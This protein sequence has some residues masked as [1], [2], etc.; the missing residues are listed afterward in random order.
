MEQW[1]DSAYGATIK[2]TITIRDLDEG[3]KTRL[4]I[5]AA[6]NG[7]SIE[8][9]A[10][11]ILLAALDVETAP[12][13]DLATLIR[14][15]FKPL[16]GAE[17][18]IPP[19]DAMRQPP[20][21]GGAINDGP[22]QNSPVGGKCPSKIT[23]DRFAA[24]VPGWYTEYMDSKYYQGYLKLLEDLPK[25]VESLG[26]LEIEDLCRIAD[27]GGNQH[28]V[29][30]NL[31]RHNTPSLVQAKT[32]EAIGH[33][34]DPG[35]AIEAVMDLQKWGLTYGSKTLM[36]MIPSDYAILDGH[37]RRALAQFLP[38][39]RDGD[40]V[41]MVRGY[42]VFLEICAGLQRE[43]RGPVP[44]TQAEWRTADIQQAVFQFAQSGG[45]FTR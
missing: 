2:A 4:R 7:H 34:K 45:T 28:G 18:E 36:F 35:R 30:Q 9:E 6:A 19:R 21:F 17:L 41:S 43:V 20:R 1:D 33:Y 3:L 25:K 14:E 31:C 16:G 10:R 29:K 39:I 5:R 26:Y 11:R 13:K 15:R 8:E 37:I 24:V 38:S 42:T 44:G 22:V 27:W 32:K 23:L 40:R 12:P